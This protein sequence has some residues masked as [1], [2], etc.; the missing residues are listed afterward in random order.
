VISFNM[1]HGF[2]SFDHLS[3]R[4]DLIA[5]EIDRHGAD[6]VLLQEVP[7]TFKTRSA[8]RFL[9]EKTGMNYAALRANGN[10]WAIG[11]EEG[12][13]ILSRY[14]ILETEF[15]ELMPKSG[16]FEHRVVLGATLDTPLG[17][18][19]V[20]S[21][22]LTNGDPEI[23][24]EQAA[25]LSAFAQG[26]GMSILAGDFNAQP[27]SPQIKACQSF[28]VDAFAAA[29][30]DTCCVDDLMLHDQIPGKR[31]YYL[32]LSPQL[33]EASRMTVSLVF[34][35]PYSL[36][37]GWLWASDH[38]GLIVTIEAVPSGDGAD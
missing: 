21:T 10:R 6:I 18:L 7:W 38:L 36:D 25:A 9:A 14:P 3:Q 19:K 1:L 12:E 37:P 28:W 15:E 27:H 29:P 33:A 22:H 35:Q 5:T 23:N 30:K 8:A 17:A 11:F 20:F 24:Q 2:P 26:D 32:F 4:L 13:A 34:D 31:I 16:L